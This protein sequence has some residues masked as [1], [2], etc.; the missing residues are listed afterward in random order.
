[1]PDWVSECPVDRVPIGQSAHWT[2]CPLDRVP[3][4]QSAQLTECPVDRVSIEQSAQWTEC[5]LWN[6]PVLE[7]ENS[8][9]TIIGTDRC[10][11][12]PEKDYRKH[13]K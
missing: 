4:G 6:R 1:M 12:P 9:L 10:P 3:I 2:E 11:C 7:T 13:A 8:G 5:P